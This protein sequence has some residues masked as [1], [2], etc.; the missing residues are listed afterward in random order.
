MTEPEERPQAFEVLVGREWSVR[1]GRPELE[2]GVNV[3]LLQLTEALVLAPR[4]QALL[5][6]VLELADRR[7]L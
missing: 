3:E 5:E 4:D 6:E 1:P 2:E 7:R